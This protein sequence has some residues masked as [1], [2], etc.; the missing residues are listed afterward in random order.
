M[1]TFALAFA[2]GAFAQVVTPQSLMRAEQA[3]HTALRMNRGRV[4]SMDAGPVQV[5]QT[6]ILVW[7]DKK[8][9]LP[10]E[11]IKIRAMGLAS[12]A[13]QLQA[14]INE[15]FV[16]SQGY[17]A[18]PDS[19]FCEC[20]DANAGYIPSLTGTFVTLLDKRVP[21]GKSGRYD[22]TVS[23]SKLPGNGAPSMPYQATRLS[24]SVLSG[25]SNAADPVRINQVQ[26]GAG[27]GPL[28]FLT[29]RFP[30]GQPMYYFV[31]AAPY[32]GSLSNQASVVSTDGQTLVLPAWSSGM[33]ERV[34]LMTADRS[35]STTSMM[36]YVIPGNTTA[37]LPSTSTA[38]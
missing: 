31:G 9:Y 25:Q 15:Q 30:V 32:E 29:G 24:V 23:F 33:E 6:G 16:G 21:Q 7:T 1:F 18:V 38:Q 35:F 26:I 5:A 10:G 8:S 12:D 2:A 34:I 14:V 22:F 4:V 13:T 11:T 17:A 36:S 27:M 28:L 37:A 19:Y 3:R 20:G